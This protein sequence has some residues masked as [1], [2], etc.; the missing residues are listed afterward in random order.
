VIAPVS[1]A[2]P[3]QDAAF[4]DR[5]LPVMFLILRDPR[6]F[7]RDFVHAGRFRCAGGKQFRGGASGTAAP[8]A[9]GHPQGARTREQQTDKRHASY[10]HGRDG[11]GVQWLSRHLRKQRSQCGVSHGDSPQPG[12]H[13]PPQSITG[14]GY[15]RA[16][17]ANC[18]QFRWT[19]LQEVTLSLCL[20]WR[21]R[22]HLGRRPKAA[23]GE[24]ESNGD[25]EVRL[26]AIAPL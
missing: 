21:R 7:L 15:R 24:L 19:S 6:K 8:A 16:C 17:G 23:P 22:M 25:S 4:K 18:G 1:A 11:Q 2:W 9:P 12:C 5:A 14:Q 13:L 20:Q 3:G 26:C 10:D